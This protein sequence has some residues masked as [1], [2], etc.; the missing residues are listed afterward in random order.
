MSKTDIA[1]DFSAEVSHQRKVA[2]LLAIAGIP[3]LFG[4]SKA[5]EAYFQ[6]PLSVF[7]IYFMFASYTAI[8]VGISLKMAKRKCPNCN[9][10]FGFSGLQRVVNFGQCPKCEFKRQSAK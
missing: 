1:A 5:Y 7:A 6:T 9:Q 10:P 2:G 4:F 3:F 8:S